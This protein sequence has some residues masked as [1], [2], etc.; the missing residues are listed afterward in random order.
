MTYYYFL[1]IAGVFA[2]SC[3]Q[4]LLKVSAVKNYRSKIQ[5]ILNWQVILAYCIF[6]GS[7]LIN[8][9]A[10]SHGV[11]LKDMPALESLSALFVPLLSS[12]ILRESITKRTLGAF[13]LIITGLWIFYS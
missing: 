11:L 4:V 2:A 5:F 1:V 12:F 13:A 3:S 10:F 8:I 6:L 7:L 9:Y